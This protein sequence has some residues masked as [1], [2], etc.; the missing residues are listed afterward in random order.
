METAS[1][2]VIKKE[3]QNLNKSDLL[4]YLIRVV[5]YKKE[6]KELISYLLFEC[7]NDKKF[8][9]DLKEMII[10]NLIQLN[11]SHVYYVKKGL[12]KM[13]RIMNK[14]LKY[15][16]KSDIKVEVMIFCCQQMNEYKIPYKKSPQL[17][18]MYD[19]LIKKI[20]IE[21]DSMHED[22]QYDYRKMLTD[23]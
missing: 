1:V 9:S 12:R 4:A 15:A 23:L 7:D 11:M 13:I 19:S 21:I 10:E 16:S 6:N 20:N 22:L 5:K 2:S 14:Y 18:N 3:L 8:T 17:Q